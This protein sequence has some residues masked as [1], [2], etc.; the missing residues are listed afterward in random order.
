MRLFPQG[1]IKLSS[2]LYTFCG[3]AEQKACPAPHG[4]V[5][6]K[7]QAV[8]MMKSKEGDI[9]NLRRQNSCVKFFCRG[10]TEKKAF[11]LKTTQIIHTA[12]IMPGSSNMRIML[13]CCGSGCKSFRCRESDKLSIYHL[14]NDPQLKRWWMVKTWS[15]TG[16]YI[17]R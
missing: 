5:H 1:S 17:S 13:Y 6:I 14:L 10:V 9:Q 3:D 2:S 11:W 4:M 15:H 8:Q 7:V 12:A 16:P